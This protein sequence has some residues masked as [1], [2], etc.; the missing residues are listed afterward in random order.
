MK[1][2]MFTDDLTKAVLEGR[3]TMTRRIM[4][5]Q[6][7]DMCAKLQLDEQGRLYWRLAGDAGFPE[8]GRF[9]RPPFEANTIVALAQRYSDIVVQDPSLEDVLIKRLHLEDAPGWSNKMYVASELMPHQIRINSWR[10]ERLQDITEED[11]LREGI[12][13]VPFC[14]WG[15]EDNGANFET[16]REAFAA[17]INLISGKG[18]WE[19]NPWVWVFDFNLV[20]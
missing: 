17:L 7:D 11:C 18:T 6:T 13:E 10:V 5:V 8:G 20:R 2:I 19:R 15:W 3:K 4:A 16:P 14:A 12:Y 9:F 1:K